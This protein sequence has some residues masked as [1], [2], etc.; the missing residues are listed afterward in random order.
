MFVA[1]DLLMV[2]AF[3]IHLILEIYFWIIIV[4]VLISWV[5]PDPTNPIVRAL[6]R[7]TDPLLDPIREK[8]FRFTGYGGMG[9][10]VS[11]IILI[12]AVK[13]LDYALSTILHDVAVHLR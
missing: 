10:D 5:N 8:L 4:R 7:V 9:I 12:I 2:L 3:A 6:N 1:A 11:P 13:V